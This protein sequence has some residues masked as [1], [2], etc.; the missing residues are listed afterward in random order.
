MNLAKWLIV[1]KS[2]RQIGGES[3]R[4]VLPLST[5]S[6]PDIKSVLYPR[7]LER[8]TYHVAQDVREED[9]IHDE[10]NRATIQPTPQVES[11]KTNETVVQNTPQNIC[12]K[13][14]QVNKPEVTDKPEITQKQTVPDGFAN[15][16]TNNQM[17]LD[18]WF[19]RGG[20]YTNSGRSTTGTSRFQISKLNFRRG[21][22]KA[23]APP[24]I[25]TGFRFKSIE[26]ARNELKYSDIE[27]VAKP[28]KGKFVGFIYNACSLI[29]EKIRTLFKKLVP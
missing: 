20:V 6:R 27:I 9:A 10:I 19:A 26:I 29:S 8:K 18:D 1:N 3:S 13:P 24:P 22:K 25:Q 17:T 28:V 5:A 4:F 12:Q 11:Q 2:V 23:P 7:L 14:V 21:F 16:K 15:N